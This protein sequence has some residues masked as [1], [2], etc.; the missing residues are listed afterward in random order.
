MEE[1]TPKCSK[2]ES[3]ESEPVA[4]GVKS[5]VESVKS[6][7][8][9][10]SGEDHVMVAKEKQTDSEQVRKQVDPDS[11]QKKTVSMEVEA[12]SRCSQ[13]KHNESK[14]D[15]ET[16]LPKVLENGTSSHGGH[17]VDKRAVTLAV[18]KSKFG[19]KSGV[20]DKTVITALLDLESTAQVISLDLIVMF[21]AGEI[22]ATKTMNTQTFGATM[23]VSFTLGVDGKCCT[24]TMFKA[25]VS[26]TP[27]FGSFAQAITKD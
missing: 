25:F 22:A 19:G 24:T 20:P 26:Q 7:N 17:A 1:T 13:N 5:A 8:T 21:K 27:V 2:N 18:E 12:L 15:W 14:V 4:Q 23:E 6:C 16:V 9:Y 3:G 11:E 10:C